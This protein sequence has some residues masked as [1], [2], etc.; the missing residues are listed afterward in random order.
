M[1]SRN[2]YPTGAG[3][4]RGLVDGDVAQPRMERGGYRQTRWHFIL[5]A[6]EI[7]RTS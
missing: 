2:R 3:V 7:R 4:G 5:G 6:M 1:N